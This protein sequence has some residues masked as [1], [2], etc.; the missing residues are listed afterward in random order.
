LFAV[1]LRIIKN[2]TEYNKKQLWGLFNVL[3]DKLKDAIF[4]EETAKAIAN[5]C[6]THKITDD[7]KSKIAKLAGDSLMGLL[8]PDKL[9]TAI[10]TEIKIEQSE[11]EKIALEIN[12]F[13]LYPVKE[14]LSPLYKVEFAPGGK[15]IKSKIDKNKVVVNKTKK[16]SQKDTYREFVD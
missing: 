12:R 9:Q 4:S 3:P 14:A 16:T 7:K 5:I 10:E 2:M 11:A 1:K 15:I 8:P 13:I 6:A